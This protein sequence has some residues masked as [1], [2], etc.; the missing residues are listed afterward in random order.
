M[1]PLQAL[2]APPQ[3]RSKEEIEETVVAVVTIGGT[4]LVM[5]PKNAAKL[6]EILS[7]QNFQ[8]SYNG[9]HEQPWKELPKKYNSTMEMQVTTMMK[10]KPLPPE[11]ED[12]PKTEAEIGRGK[13][14]PD[15]EK[16]P[17][18]VD[19]EDPSTF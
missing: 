17:V 14:G 11:R 8:V 2:F 15:E 19:P 5:H 3:R 1:N 6:M 13:S 16:A 7:M 12:T 18:G 4:S 10:I 9:S